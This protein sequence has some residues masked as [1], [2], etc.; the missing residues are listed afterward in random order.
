MEFFVGMAWLASLLVKIDLSVDL[1]E[2]TFVF[3]A[4]LLAWDAIQ[5]TSMSFRFS[6]ARD[7]N[8]ERGPFSAHDNQGA[9]Q[10]KVVDV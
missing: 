8:A 2:T 5:V 1:E 6:V 7:F 4:A 9:E 3:H 10:K